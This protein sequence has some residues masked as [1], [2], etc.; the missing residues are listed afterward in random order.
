MDLRACGDAESYEYASDRG[1]DTRLQEE[2]PDGDTCDDI[3]L[4]GGDAQAT[5]EEEKG[6]ERETKT[7]GQE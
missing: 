3:G 5:E 4:K 2:C 6:D 1:M 7:Q